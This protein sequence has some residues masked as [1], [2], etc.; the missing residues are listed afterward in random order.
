LIVAIKVDAALPG[1]E[2]RMG[3]GSDVVAELLHRLGI[4]YVCVNPGSSFRGLHD[5]LVNYNTNRDPKLLLALHEQT[6]VSIAHGYA[7]ASGEPMAAVLHSNVGLMCGMMSIFNAWCDRVPILI[8]GATGAVDTAKRRSWIDWNHT[9]RDQG[10]LVRQFVKWDEQPAS[11]EAAV[12]SVLRAYQM[13]CTPPSG[14]AYVILD[15]RLQEDALRNEIV[16]PEVTRYQP[17][18]TGSPPADSVKRAAAWLIEATRP[19]ILVGRVSQ[20]VADWDARVQLAELLE[21]RVI[22]DLR[23]GASFPTDHRLH[24][25]PA[26]LFLTGINE[27]LLASADAVLSLDWPDLAD[28][29]RQTGDRFL[30]PERKVIQVSMDFYAQNGYSGDHQR[31]AAVDLNIAA[32]PDEILR[33]LIAE[34]KRGRSG[35]P[36]IAP[37]ARKSATHKFSDQ[38]PTLADIGRALSMLRGKRKF[39]LARVPLNWPAASY[40]FHEPLDYLGYDGGGAVGSGPGMTI[41]AAIALEGKGRIVV[42]IMGDGE[43]LGAASAIWTAAHYEVPLLIVVANNRSYFTDEIQQEAVARERNRPIENKWIGQRIDGPSV[44][45]AALARDYGVQAEGPV[46]KANELLSALDR[47]VEVVEAGRPYLVDV[48]IDPTRGA[49]FDWLAGH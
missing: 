15:R 38:L 35:R 1:T 18:R 48:L 27:K 49:N 34:V 47:G 43:F 45:I 46:E 44:N 2:Q 17:P 21:A 20:N 36:A 42:G 39:C 4:K 23:T 32:M 13:A 16:L 31:L 26:D 25:G 6:V 41:G 12:D 7:K 10:A 24:G 28:C 11:P 29:L 33:P 30:T 40:D 37:S 5:S 9:F 8:L 14:P 3:W 22:T 19:V